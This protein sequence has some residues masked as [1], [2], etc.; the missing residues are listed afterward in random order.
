MTMAWLVF[1]SW[2]PTQIYK[3]EEGRGWL[4]EQRKEKAGHKR[5][6]QTGEKEVGNSRRENTAKKEKQVGEKEQEIDSFCLC[7]TAVVVAFDIQRETERKEERERG[8]AAA[9]QVKCFSCGGSIRIWQ[10]KRLP[11]TCSY[12]AALILS[13]CG[14]RRTE[15]DWE[16]A[17]YKEVSSG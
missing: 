1:S 6:R 11:V 7:I 15:T 12:M 17:A 9:A 3:P 8:K 14:A 10:Q 2:D 16:N 13:R 4:E 5:R